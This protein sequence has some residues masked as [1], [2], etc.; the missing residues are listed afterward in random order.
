[1]S[2]LRYLSEHAEKKEKNCYQII[3]KTAFI[4]E[5]IKQIHKKPKKIAPDSKGSA[6][7]KKKPKLSDQHAKMFILKLSRSTRC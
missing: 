2:S 3:L 1:M 6:I 7:T 4:L 5:K